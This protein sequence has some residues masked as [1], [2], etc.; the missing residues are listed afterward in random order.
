M[1]WLSQYRGKIRILGSKKP[2]VILIIFMLLITIF[3]VI[4]PSTN[5]S[6]IQGARTV[7]KNVVGPIF[8]SSSTTRG[9]RSIGFTDNSTG[10]PSSGGYNFVAFGDINNDGKI[11]IAAGGEDRGSLTTTGLYAYIGNGGTSWSSASTG[12]WTGNSWGGVQLADADG[13]GN[14][15]LYSTD[16][17]WGTFNSSGLKV[18][19]YRSG[20]W[21]DS[22][23]HVSTPLS[24]GLPDN[25][26]IENITGDNKLDL[27]VS[28]ST[29]GLSY[30]ENTGG[31]PVAWVKKEKGL[32]TS[33]EYTTFAIADMNKDGLKDIVACDYSG[34]EHLFVQRTSGN[35]WAEYSTGLSISGN[36]LGVAVGDVNG[37]THMDIVYGRQGSGLRCLLGNSGGGSGGTSFSWTAANT[38]LS[39][40]GQYWQ[41]AVI[42]RGLRFMLVTAPPL[43]V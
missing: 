20:A 2:L 15:E 19:E 18:F 14:I 41:I 5:M 38:G 16:E 31:N 17:R 23:T 33:S 8:S 21:T 26:K 24:S 37:D 43:Q 22:T 27:V 32:P 28:N 40:S 7:E 1:D 3:I 12:L 4:L 39:T 6:K 9:A 29:T 10:L 42:I 36:V 11:D 13:D 30:F 25:V 35:L 34:G